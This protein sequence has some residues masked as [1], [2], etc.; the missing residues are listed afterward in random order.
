MMASLTST[1]VVSTFS[2]Y[3]TGS[4]YISLIHCFWRW[5]LTLILNEI[6]PCLIRRGRAVA[7]GVPKPL[8]PTRTAPG[9]RFGRRIV[10]V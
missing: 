4:L 1:W 6:A 3:G 7:F 10:R 9:R 8:P 2:W 5:L